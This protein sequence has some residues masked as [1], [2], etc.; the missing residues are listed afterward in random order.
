MPTNEYKASCI[1]IVY[2]SL[3]VLFNNAVCINWKSSMVPIFVVL[4]AVLL[5]FHAFY[6][7]TLCCGVSVSDVSNGCGVFILR[8][9]Q[10]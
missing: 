6:G 8:F 1:C 4:T 3:F 10:S 7:V 5:R 2:P 9:K